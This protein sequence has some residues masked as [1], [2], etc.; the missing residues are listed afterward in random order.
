MNTAKRVAKNTG[1]LY[2][3]MAINVI[4]ALYS[5]RLILDALGVEDFGIFNLVAG[6]IGML[7]FLN[8]A[9]TEASQR[10]M[11]YAQ[12][13][14]AELKQKRVFNVSMLL[15]I[16]MVVIVLLILEVAG[17]F[18]FRGVLEIPEN[19]VKVAKIVYQFMILSTLFT[20]IKVPYDAVLN[21]HEN[22]FLVALLGII[23]SLLK[24]G[25]ALYITYTKFDQLI[26]YGLLMAVL[27][28]VILIITRTYCHKKYKEV[29][30]KLI[31]HSDKKIFKEMMGFA[32]YRTLT[33]S[34]FIF[35]MQGTSI[36]LNSFF[37][38]V[39]NAAQGIANQITVQLANFSKTMLK[40]LNP[41]IVKSEGEKNRKQM[42]RISMLGS[43]I[44]F[45]LITFL[46]VPV[47]IEM[48]FIFKIWL[49]DI[50]EYA[51]VFGRLNLLR[52]PFSLLT[53]TLPV[54]I[55]AIG[56]I[57]EVSIWESV[58]F[59][60][61]LPAS[62]IMYKLG[63]P[64]QVIYKNLILMVIGVAAVRVYFLKK[65]GGLSIKLFV[66]NNVV[67]CLGVFVVT[68][69]I[70]SVPLLYYDEGFVRLIIVVFLSS[71]A[72]VGTAILFGLNKNEKHQVKL[73][74][75]SLREKIK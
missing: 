28:L 59:V 42:L 54:A 16:I 36:I 74:L 5:T 37:G 64:P 20:I 15:H 13:E 18:L 40:A 47:L 73:L 7:T 48:P 12:G 31:K 30:L 63:S 61:V 25:I 26:T 21:A 23:H 6:V 1:F 65:L 67:R 27:S 43:K 9:M 49:K 55:G 52:I 35:T 51:V 41:V 72:F 8:S 57:K 45:F 66:L 3:R 69:L 38:V 14:A 10:F 11:A 2:V 33:T 53:V 56:R 60:A 62:Y 71:V 50:P 24:L 46:S 68:V 44:S 22:M 29:E 34:V 17:Y 4:V 75:S 19:R 58:F 39:V 32:G 70:A